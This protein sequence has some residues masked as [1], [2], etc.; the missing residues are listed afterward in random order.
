MPLGS[1]SAAPVINPG[2][3]AL[4]N[5]DKLN[6]RARNGSF[7]ILIPLKPKPDRPA[8]DPPPP[9]GVVEML[10]RERKHFGWGTEGSRE[11]GPPPEASSLR[12]GASTT[13][14][15]GGEPFF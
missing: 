4:T 1:S 10:K 12:S 2:P 11:R 7:P 14:Q 13:P 9:C 3:S 8:I 15:G 5:R 6:R